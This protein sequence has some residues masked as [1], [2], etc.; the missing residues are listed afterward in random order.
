M[1]ALGFVAILA[2]ACSKRTM[3]PE[4][5]FVAET[6]AFE[7]LRTMIESESTCPYL[8]ADHYEWSEACN[9][10]P[11]V[12][13]V[14]IPTGAPPGTTPRE[15]SWP[16]G[17]RRWIQEEPTPE[18]LAAICKMPIARAGEY[19]DTMQRIGALRLERGG[20]EIAF[21]VDFQGIVTSGSVTSIVWRSAP[22][23][24]LRTGTDYKGTEYRALGPHWWLRREWN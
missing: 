6:A 13:A 14:A 1:R 2:L 12:G 11:C 18:L 21:V 17:C 16:G 7:R 24:S 23:S 9:T 8:W 10:G 3:A 19:L 5:R 4:E 20:D 15:C 22:P